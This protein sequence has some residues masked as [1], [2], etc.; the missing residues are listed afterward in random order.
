MCGSPTL[1]CTPPQIIYK[2]AEFHLQE[3]CTTLDELPDLPK[4]NETGYY[5]LDLF[6]QSEEKLNYSAIQLVKRDTEFL[7]KVARGEVPSTKETHQQL[8]DICT[9]KVNVIPCRM[10]KNSPVYMNGFKYP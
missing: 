1:I 3:A 6:L 5:P 2:K 9:Q 4:T 7:L 8:V 10:S